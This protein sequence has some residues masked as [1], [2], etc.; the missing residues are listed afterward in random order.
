M[1]FIE[2]NISDWFDSNMKVFQHEEFIDLLMRDNSIVKLPEHGN[3]YYFMI[4]VNTSEI[5]T[6]IGMDNVPFEQNWE[7][8]EEMRM[9][10][11]LYFIFK[12]WGQLPGNLKIEKD[13]SQYEGKIFAVPANTIMSILNKIAPQDPQRFN[14]VNLKKTQTIGK[15]IKIEQE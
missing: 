14:I 10:N 3:G 12:M 11:I 4:I 13:V 7:L 2:K 5:E 9:N 1:N 8:F 6:G 15:Y